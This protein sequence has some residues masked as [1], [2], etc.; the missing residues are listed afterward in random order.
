MFSAPNYRDEFNV[1][2]RECGEIDKHA[3]VDLMLSHMSQDRP[4]PI[5]SERPHFIR[6]SSPHLFVVRNGMDTRLELHAPQDEVGMTLCPI[7]REQS[8][9]GFNMGLEALK[10]SQDDA[11]K[12]MDDVADKILSRLEIGVDYADHGDLPGY[13]HMT[14]LDETG[15][16]LMQIKNPESYLGSGNLSAL[17]SASADI[18]PGAS[19][20]SPETMEGLWTLAL[21]LKIQQQAEI[22][23]TKY[24][25]MKKGIPKLYSGNRDSVSKMLLALDAA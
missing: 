21:A 22:D 14:R 24:D 20:V 10:K 9:F 6:A 12:I 1:L 15:N 11:E 17:F 19:P 16:M 7:T 23:H 13:L 2:S 4:R 18:A 3:H 5:F 25:L 8:T